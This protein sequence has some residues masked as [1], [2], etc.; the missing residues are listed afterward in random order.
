MTLFSDLISDIIG[1]NTIMRDNE[2]FSQ[3]RPVISKKNLINSYRRDLRAETSEEFERYFRYRYGSLTYISMLNDA[4]L[5]SGYYKVSKN[6]EE[7]IEACLEYIP[8]P[9][10]DINKDYS[11]SPPQKKYPISYY[12]S[13]YIRIE[14]DSSSNYKPI[15]HPCSHLHIGLETDYHIALHRYPFYSEFVKL[16]LFFN[17]QEDW[18]KLVP[19]KQN[20][21]SKDKDKL[22]FD[23]YKRQRKK[24]KRDTFIESLISD[25][26]AEFYNF[27]W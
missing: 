25:M 27:S 9:G 5:L 10:L 19:K 4:S 3:V 1:T 16:I 14:W 21:S 20:I 12:C 23:E 26:E 13:R 15:L 24:E 7:L 11:S 17:Y 22:D 2:I 6:N 8:N 18:K